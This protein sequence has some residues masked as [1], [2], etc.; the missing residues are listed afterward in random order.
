MKIDYDSVRF[1][2]SDDLKLRLMMFMNGKN[3][4]NNGCSIYL[5]IKEDLSQFEEDQFRTFVPEY[6]V[7][8]YFYIRNGREY[9]DEVIDRLNNIENLNPYRDFNDHDFVKE[10]IPSLIFNL[11]EVYAS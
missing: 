8:L 10:R 9:I 1:V 6:C 11:C 7:G 2:F 5:D 4:V 3:T